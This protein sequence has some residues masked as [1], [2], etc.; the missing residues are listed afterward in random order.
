MATCRV[1]FR[2]GLHLLELYLQSKF[3]EKAKAIGL[4]FAPCMLHQPAALHCS[5]PWFSLGL[6]GPE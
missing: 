4:V 1:H 2:A 5:S 3:H 6:E